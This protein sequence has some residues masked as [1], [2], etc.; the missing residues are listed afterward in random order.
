MTCRLLPLL[1]LLSMLRTSSSAAS[2]GLLSP[3]FNALKHCDNE[4]KKLQHWWQ[5][6]ISDLQF[7][8]RH[9]NAATSELARLKPT[10]MN[11][12]ITGALGGIGQAIVSKLAVHGVTNRTISVLSRLERFPE[13]KLFAE[14]LGQHIRPYALDLNIGPNATSL[15]DLLTTILDRTD[16]IR[17]NNSGRVD[18]VIHNAGLMAKRSSVRDIHAV[19]YYAPVVLSL[20]LLPDMMMTSKNPVLMFVGSSSHLRGSPVQPQPQPP[21]NHPRL[22][23]MSSRPNSMKVVGAYGDAK[24]R[25]LLAAT[26]LERRFEATGLHVRT[27]H[28]GLVDTPMLQ[29]FFG[30]FSFPWRKQFLRPPAEGAAAVLIPS[31]SVFD[32]IFYQPAEVDPVWKQRDYRREYYVNGFSA[33][34]KCTAMVNDAAACEACLQ[35]VMRDIRLGADPAV[36]ARLVSRIRDAAPA[37]GL[38]GDLSDEIKAAR[39]Q[40]LLALALDLE[41]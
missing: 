10:P 2:R 19:N 39:R 13:L 29:G 24:L 8:M 25:L 27:A 11:V 1:L 40:S 16:A 20:A 38:N 7:N 9:P 5:S 34:A 41:R 22:F 28:P 30:S 31:T 33:P 17:L 23:A 4:S 6:I 14:R 26:A 35:E 3:L 15:D 36:R 12:V 32:V 18:L 21:T 37:C